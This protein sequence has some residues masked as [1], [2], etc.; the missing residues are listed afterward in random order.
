[1]DRRTRKKGVL[2]KQTRTG[3]RRELK[4][5]KM[6]PLLYNR[7]VSYGDIED[8]HQISLKLQWKARRGGKSF[9]LRA[10]GQGADV[11]KQ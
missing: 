11:W 5:K 10:T 7:M 9:V 1:M 2:T 3:K 6:C 8:W 4:G